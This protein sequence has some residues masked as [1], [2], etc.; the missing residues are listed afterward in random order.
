MSLTT[1]A[2]HAEWLSLVP[3]SGPFI[4]LP[5]LKKVFPQGLDGLN[6]DKLRHVRASYSAFSE[7]VKAGALVRLELT[8]WVQ[9]VLTE[10]L[11]YPAELL[12][13]GQSLPANLSALVP[14]YHVTLRPTLAIVEPGDTAARR[15]RMLVSVFPHETNLE[16]AL[17]VDGWRESPIGRMTYLLRAT[18]VQLGL[19]TN[20][21]EWA[22]INAISGKA[23][24]ISTWEAGLWT[25]ET[26]TFQSFC[27][28][29]N[30]RRLFGVAESERLEALFNDSVEFQQEVTEQLGLQVRRAIEILVYQLDRANRERNGEL[31]QNVNEAQVYEAAVTF[32]MRLVF[33]FFAEENKL[34][35][36]DDQLYA[37]SYAATTIREQLRDLADKAGEEVLE[38]QF[39]AYSR[40]LATFRA[41]HGGAH[42]HD[43]SIPP[44][45]GHL[46]DPDRFPFLEGRKVGS[47]WRETIASPLP[48]HNRTVLHLLEALQTIDGRILSFRG[49]D[50]EQIGHVY[51]GLLDHTVKRADD[52]TVSLKGAGK[53]AGDEPEVE[54][55]ELERL[56]AMPRAKY[57]SELAERTG[58]SIKSIEKSLSAVVT[59]DE[60]ARLRI[61]AGNDE[62]I[63]ARVVPFSGIIRRDSTEL[64]VVVTP[65][66]F[67]VT[68]GAD[69]RSTGTH[70][71][72][73]SLT[74]LIVQHALDPVAY[75][76]PAEGAE[77]G[78]WKLKSP[79]E[80]LQLRVCDFACGSGAFLVQA[81]RYLG[82][83]LVESWA[84]LERDNAGQVV[85]SPEGLLAEK[86]PLTSVVPRADDERMVLA[87]RIVAERCL[88]GVDKN[89]LAAEMAKLS[90]WLI[91]LDR[92]RPFTFLD[93][94]IRCGD[95]LLGVG[96]LPQLEYFNLLSESDPWAKQNSGYISTY[97]KGAV[98]SAAKVIAEISAIPVLE[99]ADAER[100]EQMYRDVVESTRA[101]RVI[102]DLLVASSFATGEAR[103]DKFF[104]HVA[105]YWG[106]L[107]SLFEDKLSEASRKQLLL[108]LSSHAQAEVDDDAPASQ[109][110]RRLFH[111]PIEFPEVFEAGG[112]SAILGNPPFIGGRKIRA[113]LGGDM[114]EYLTNLPFGSTSGNADLCALF[115]LRGAGLLADRS[116]L[117]LIATN[118]LA[119]GD[120]RETGLARLEEQKFSIYRATPST[121][122][123]GDAAVEV[124]HCWAI[125]GEWKGQH[126]LSDSPVEGI[127]SFFTLPG[128]VAGTPHRLLENAGKS[129]Q[130]SIVLGM[131]FV[132]DAVEARSLIAADARNADVILPYLNGED[133]NSRPDQSPSRWVINFHDWPIERAM[134]YRDVFRIVEERVKPERQ[135]I[136]DSGE[137]VLRKP[138]P[139]KWWI[140]A[141]KRPALYG[142]LHGMSRALVRSQVAKHSIYC[143]VPTGIV[144]DQRLVCFVTD[145]ADFFITLQSGIH[146]AWA[147]K[148]SSTLKSDLQYSPSD[149]FLTFP[150]PAFSAEIEA[151]G[152]TYLEARKQCCSKR[153]IGMTDFYNLLGNR[154]ETS[155]DIAE[156]RS[157]IVRSDSAILKQYGW[158]DITLTYDFEPSSRGF[159]YRLGQKSIDEIVARLL[160]LNHIRVEIAADTNGDRSSRAS[161]ADEPT[162]RQGS[163]F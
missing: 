144:F 19:I 138:L 163:L 73:R 155:T 159:K 77:R 71:T 60:L 24:A 11:E 97:T 129:Y 25:E 140:Y 132:L 109:K 134:E 35:P 56:S 152:T 90:L 16:R 103:G 79:L 86:L 38:R 102:A 94:H 124:A 104:A 98:R 122:W 151:L 37:A 131:G 65:A 95:S 107:K 105:R 27:S 14:E 72:P 62:A 55:S 150:F 34:L 23:V 82:A 43:M 75:V 52:L 148:Y 32:M 59:P 45:G 26:I 64:P 118:T 92:N 123:P 70:Y 153:H 66:G 31:L 145:R 51:E 125:K 42:H 80:L 22:L 100:K 44:Y 112:F 84:Q 63:L 127:N 46:F 142:A 114:F 128:R 108:E 139:Q 6:R 83:R 67:F 158:D 119:Q 101:L 41:V 17:T 69:R 89:H 99:I 12:L 5:V 78:D 154:N 47:S 53:F 147:W 9:F 135:R 61:A 4:S 20:G 54:V 106:K 133:L 143:F 57:V 15:P 111:W 113:A 141:D 68:S 28:L 48:I 85:I 40:L 126:W 117:G 115:F 18:G 1:N 121:P 136:S 116:T 146:D 156:F 49:L 21:D 30:A 2:H 88:Y 39:D 91:T 10:I 160:E 7:A 120:T 87:R 13:E 110:P 76:G 8:K 29:L 137:F 50:I 36:I 96:S 33:L 3:H 157:L 149:C 130:G 162:P 58:V 74:E 81:C 161:N 93:H